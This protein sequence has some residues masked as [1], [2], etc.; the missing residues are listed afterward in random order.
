M[1]CSTPFYLLYATLLYT[2]LLYCTFLD[3]NNPK[4]IDE[5]ETK[6]PKL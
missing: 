5:T 3:C 1:L 6:N 2:T 4:K